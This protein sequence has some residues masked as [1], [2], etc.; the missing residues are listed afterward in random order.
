M[1][2]LQTLQ[3]KFHEYLLDPEHHPDI[4]DSIVSTEKVSAQTRLSIY[5][6]AYRLRLLGLL[7]MDYPFAQQ[8]MGESLFDELG[9]EYIDVCTPDHYSPI[10]FSRH[11]SR[12]LAEHHLEQ[13]LY[14]EFAA[15][16]W[17]L[18]EV[19]LAEDTPHLEATTLAETPPEDWPGLTFKLH[20]SFKIIPM[21][22]NA[23]EFYRAMLKEGALP[24]EVIIEQNTAATHW[25]IW[26]FERS[27]YFQSL[28]PEQAGMLQAIQTKQSFIE[29]CAGLCE[30]F[31]FSEEQA[32]Q[33]TAQNLHYFIQWHI[34]A[35]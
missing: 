1:S 35:A 22:T 20:P 30:Q 17:G 28:T 24:E 10:Y 31:H 6:N 9:N 3:L 19:L 34:F 11:F 14:A 2:Q 21:R 32:G 25:A 33:F 15:L 29:L 13:A 18:L 16:E 8:L 23:P 12:F 7:A 4:Q 27:P 26:R 5:S